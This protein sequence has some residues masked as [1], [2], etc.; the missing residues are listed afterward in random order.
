MRR[1]IGFSVLA[2]VVLSGCG[3]SSTS[4]S[5]AP[6]TSSSSANSTRAASASAKSLSVT[7]TEFKLTPASPSVAAGQVHVT[8]RN[9]GKVMHALVIK[10]AGPGGKDLR[11]A[12]VK[13][14]ATTTVTAALTP[15]R[16]Y[17]WYCPI[18]G[19]KGLGMKGTITVTSGGSA[20]AAPAAT[21]PSPAS[22][23]TSSSKGYAY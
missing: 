5:P 3:S 11:S 23:T 2:V 20:T 18:D 4:G 15:G 22:S 7:E 1:I 8:V 12:D 9:S 10:N 19:H 21:T 6:G 17:Q 14:G 13:P 16:T